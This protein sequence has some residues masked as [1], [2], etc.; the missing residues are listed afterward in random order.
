[1]P[2]DT[3]GRALTKH[4][5]HTYQTTCYRVSEEDGLNKHHFGTLSRM[6]HFNLLALEY[7]AD[8]EEIYRSMNKVW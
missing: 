3:Q 1:M 5:A 7:Q 8:I 6:Q 2:E 4:S